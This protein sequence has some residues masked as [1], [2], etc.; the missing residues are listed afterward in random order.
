LPEAEKEF[1]YLRAG[2]SMLERYLLSGEMYWPV[3]VSQKSGELLYPS[4]TLSGMLL[5]RARLSGFELPENLRFEREQID[6]ELERLAVHWRVAWENKAACEF[7][8]R[9]N[10]W[11]SFL[12]EYLL[13]PENHADRYA[14]EVSRRVMLDLLLPYSQQ[15]PEVEIELIKR[16]DVSLRAVIV[17]GDFIWESKLSQAFPTNKYWYLYGRLR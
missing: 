7:H 5:A 9:S 6:R 13:H 4:L 1:N 8:A 11:R 12:E 17:P 10:L 16:L 3:Q 14:Y 15:V 2:L